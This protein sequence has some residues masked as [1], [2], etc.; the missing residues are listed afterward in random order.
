MR[1]GRTLP[2]LRLGEVRLGRT[3]PLLRLGEV[4]LGRTLPLLRLG[5]V[6]LGVVALELRLDSLGRTVV[7]LRSMR[8]LVALPREEREDV[9]GA[10]ERAAPVV[11][12]LPERAVR[13]R[14]AP[15]VALELRAAAEA[16]GGA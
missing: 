16:T 3:L 8:L 1:L 12:R 14:S 5:E 6:R 15:L 4:R 11:V 10:V 13:T 2:L 7:R 9:D